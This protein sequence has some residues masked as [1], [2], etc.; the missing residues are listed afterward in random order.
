MIFDT[1]IHLNEP[2][3]LE[4]LDRYLLEARKKGVT[5]FLCVGWD[6]ESSKLAV[7][8]AE[9]YEG[10]YAAI[11]V[12][13]TE[14][15]SYKTLEENE[16]TVKELEKLLGTSSKILAIGEIGLDYYWEKE[17]QIKAKQKIMFLEQIELA[18]KYN[19]PVSIHTRDAIQDA[20]D[21]LKSNK[22][23]ESG[24][25]HCYS[26]SK[27]M[28]KEFIKLGYKIAFGGVLTFKNSKETKEVI[29]N[30][31]LDDIVFETDAPYLAPVPY[32]GKMCEPSFIFET[33]KY[34]SELLND[35]Q[36]EL[37]KITFRNSCKILHVKNYEQI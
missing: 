31:S 24:I 33:V 10:V 14:H 12:I 2:R 20:F 34:A 19:L 13:P 36:D 22:V 21:I 8:I 3:I 23:K 30:I 16:P 27:E 17:E 25:M 5:S 29:K 4:N 9:K 37:E 26:G 32:R 11:G 35:D 18:N 7:K 28:A 1:H 15:K 6:L